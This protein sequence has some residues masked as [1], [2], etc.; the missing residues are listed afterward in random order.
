MKTNALIGSALLASLLTA[1]CDNILGGDNYDEPETVL[2]GEVTYQGE[3]AGIRTSA[4]QLQ[5]WQTDPGY[6]IVDFIPVYV[7]QEGFFSTKIFDG[8]YELALAPNNG[9]WVSSTTRIPVAV[10]GNT[11]IDV[12]VQPYYTITEPRIAHN[13]AVNQP[14]GAITA[15]FKV[16]QVN[17]ANQLEFVGVYIGLTRFV[18]RSPN[19]IAIANNLRERARSLIQTQLNTNGDITISINLPNTIHNTPGPDRRDFVFVRIGVK[20]VGVAELWYTPVQEIAI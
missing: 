8:N 6:E 16:G 5:L 19:T 20:T 10:N 14:Y 12:P 18:D 11:T 15:T 7:N 17:T 2:S 9:P 13:P 3:P 4:I 1:G